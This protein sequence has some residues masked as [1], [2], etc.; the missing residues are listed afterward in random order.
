MECP[1]CDPKRFESDM[2][3]TTDHFIFFHD[4]KPIT[5]GHSLLIPSFHI[6]GE[7]E[8]PKEYRDEYWEA[9]KRAF[10][11]ITEHYSYDPLVF[12]NPPH[13]QS[14]THL[15]KHFIPGV[16]G[17]LGVDEALRKFLEQKNIGKP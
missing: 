5:L 17:V 8:I 9:N 2:I 4:Y 12:I 10:E 14:V 15:H 11:W 6:R 16:F 13:Q 3:F 7:S 1:F